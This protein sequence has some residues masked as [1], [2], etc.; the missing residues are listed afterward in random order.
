MEYRYVFFP[1]CSGFLAREYEV[2]GMA[3][4]GVDSRVG[5]PLVGKEE[6]E[7]TIEMNK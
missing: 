1:H 6:E 5:Q 3:W 7:R 4:T 2:P